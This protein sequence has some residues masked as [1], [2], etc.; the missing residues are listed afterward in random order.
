[1]SLAHSMNLKLAST[2]AGQIVTCATTKLL[3]NII[4]LME[5][6]PTQ[7]RDANAPESRKLNMEE[8]RKLEKLLIADIESATA[9]YDAVTKEERQAVIERLGRT[10]AAEVKTLYE[11]YKLAGKQQSELRTKL[12]A[13]GYIVS[14]NGE[15]AVNSTG[16]TAKQLAEFDDRWDEKRRS[17]AT[18]KRSYVIK[19]FADHADTQ[20]LFGSLAKDLERLVG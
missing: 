18:L 20:T 6:S 9:S 11:R 7:E 2:L 19:L 5:T 8:K 16:T 14:Y 1:M 10:P 4:H 17:L 15:L 13:L 12:N 3:T